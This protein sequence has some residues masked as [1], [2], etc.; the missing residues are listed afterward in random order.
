MSKKSSISRSR[1]LSQG[2]RS[3]K[4]RG[5]VTAFRSLGSTTSSLFAMVISPLFTFLPFLRIHPQAVC[6][7][8]LQ[9]S[10]YSAPAGFTILK[11]FLP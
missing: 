1:S 11:R 4:L 9:F 3:A 10:R 2:V 7:L 8:K 6:Q 5:G